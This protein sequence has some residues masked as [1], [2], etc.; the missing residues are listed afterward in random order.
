MEYP[1][2]VHVGNALA[3]VPYDDLGLILCE[4]SLLPNHPEQVPLDCEF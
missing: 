2:V 3:D 1:L 4:S